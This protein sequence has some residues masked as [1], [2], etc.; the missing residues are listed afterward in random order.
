MVVVMKNDKY[1][2]AF[3]FKG[4]SDFKKFHVTHTYF[5]ELDCEQI[6]EVIEITE[7]FLMHGGT[8]GKAIP[9]AFFIQFSFREYFG[10]EKNIPVLL[11][12]TTINYNFV[13]LAD[14]REKLKN[15]Q[16]GIKYPFNPHLTTELEWFNGHIEKLYL[17]KN[18]YEIVTGWLL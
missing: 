8:G 17:F 10:E 2:L 1:F 7:N 11:P 16:G 18:D 5:G 15:Y 12:I 14:L 3:T 6:E 4:I 9:G 13:L